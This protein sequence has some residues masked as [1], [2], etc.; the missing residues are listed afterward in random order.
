MTSKYSETKRLVAMSKVYQHGK[1]QI[2]AEVRK[3]LGLK[4]GDKILWIVESGKWVIER[5]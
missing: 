5:A 3:A 4:D 1:T 2:P